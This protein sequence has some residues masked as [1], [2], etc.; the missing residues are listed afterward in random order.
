MAK[1]RR[2]SVLENVAAVF[3]LFIAYCVGYRLKTCYVPTDRYQHH[4]TSA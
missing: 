4:G 3:G 2:G 1:E